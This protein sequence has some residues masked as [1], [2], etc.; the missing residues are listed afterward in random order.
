M[1]AERLELLL[2]RIAVGVEKMGADPEIEIEAGPPV[3]PT[4]GEVNPKVHLPPQEGGMGRLGE[5]M[6]E[7]TCECGAP[8]YVVIESYSNH[9]RREIA[10]EEARARIE[11]G[12][13]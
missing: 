10:V 11:Q 1:E 9:N 4:C 6:I 8:I 5:M 12:W 3:C 2:E 13:E 7:C